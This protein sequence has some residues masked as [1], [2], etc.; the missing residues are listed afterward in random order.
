MPAATPSATPLQ[1][2]V[3]APFAAALPPASEHHARDTKPAKRP[4]G[5]QPPQPPPQQRPHP[6]SPQ[7]PPPHQQPQP[8]PQ[9][10]QPQ[11]QQQQ[12]HRRKH[13]PQH[14]PR[15]SPQ[16][17]SPQH[18]P[19]Q[20]PPQPRPPKQQ[21]A[22]LLTALLALLAALGNPSKIRSVVLSL[23]RY[24]FFPRGLAAIA[25]Y[26]WWIVPVIVVKRTLGLPHTSPKSWDLSSD[27]LIH[28]V[29]FAMQG[30]D[31]RRLRQLMNLV[32][33][34]TR[35]VVWAM[36]FRLERVRRLASQSSNYV[37]EGAWIVSKGDIVPNVRSEEWKDRLVVLWIHG[38]GY[39]TG[40]CTSFA[41]ANCE[42]MRHYQDIADEIRARPLLYFSMDYPKAPEAKYPTQ[43]EATLSTYIWLVQQVGVTNIIVAGDSAGANLALNLHRTLVVLNKKTSIVLPMS[44]VLVSPWMDISR[45]H[46]P[47]HIQ[48]H[49]ATT[50]DFLSTKLLDAFASNVTPS[51][52]HRRD[53]SISPIFDLAPLE[54][55]HDG[56][57]VVYS[58]SEL[59]TPDIDDWI[60]SV[61]R[62]GENR[63]LL[64]ILRIDDMPHDFAVALH[65][66]PTPLRR[67]S[68]YALREIARF[69]F[70]S[71][72]RGAYA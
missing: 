61:R 12:Q 55:P 5:K 22:W 2:P 43:L 41:S 29:R 8:Q 48:E 15:K 21:A 56:I 42:I 34:G 28:L 26:A 71:F 31:W 58:G 23:F 32:D 69:A 44:L 37:V 46:T 35:A 64:K 10:S 4:G 62:H 9:L 47:P 54:M 60:E 70:A 13:S 65:M 67:A 40:S 72:L 63:D 68:V 27:I 66:W 51:G 6:P 24:L 25:L 20:Q 17:Q 11:P 36:G 39:T 18:P 45:S 7:M 19:N 52:L 50:S 49:L 3:L 57:F 59:L 1:Y 16:Q 30:R 14:S 33:A 38:G 53:P